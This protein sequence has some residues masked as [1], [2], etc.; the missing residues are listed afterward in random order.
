MPSGTD[1]LGTRKWIKTTFMSDALLEHRAKA[2]LNLRLPKRKVNKEIVTITSS[3]GD[4][5]CD[6]WI[7]QVAH[8]GSDKST[9]RPAILML[10]GG[11]WVHGSPL[12]DEGMHLIRALELTPEMESN[13]TDR[14][15]NDLCFGA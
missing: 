3:E 10:H 6:L 15:G 2:K 1:V 4:E 11:G 8:S 14:H 5:T 12:G 13:R 9:P 7:Y